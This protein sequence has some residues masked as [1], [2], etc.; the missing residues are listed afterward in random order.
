[1]VLPAGVNL[2]GYLSACGLLE[3]AAQRV[4]GGDRLVAVLAVVA[5][6]L[7]LVAVVGVVVGVAAGRGRA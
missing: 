5:V 6:V 1:M 3:A 2:D 4:L 7:V